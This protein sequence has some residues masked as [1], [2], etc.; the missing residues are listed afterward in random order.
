[1]ILRLL[2]F[3]NITYHNCD[4]SHDY[5]VVTINNNKLVQLVMFNYIKYVYIHAWG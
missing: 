3:L 1:M 4:N 5:K 2:Q